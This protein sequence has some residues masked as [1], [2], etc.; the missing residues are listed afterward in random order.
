MA[1]PS[2]IEWQV[3][4]AGKEA[5]IIKHLYTHEPFMD[6]CLQS[7]SM[8]DQVMAAALKTTNLRTMKAVVEAGLRLVIQVPAQLGV[9]RLRGQV[10]QRNLDEARSGPV[11]G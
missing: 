6:R 9:R 1:F 10:H 11:S 8:D 3:I 5:R 4:N 7:V 2:N